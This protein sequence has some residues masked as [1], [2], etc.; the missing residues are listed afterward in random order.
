MLLQCG[1]FQRAVNY[2]MMKIPHRSPQI[3]HLSNQ[4]T[5]PEGL[6]NLPWL[7]NNVFIFFDP[8][9]ESYG[10][11]PF[12]WELCTHTLCGHNSCEFH[13][14]YKNNFSMYLPMNPST[15]QNSNDIWI[16]G[17]CLGW[18]YHDVSASQSSHLRSLSSHLIFTFLI[19]TSSN[20][21]SSV[22]LSSLL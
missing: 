13:I 18:G 9:H 20:Y 17:G 2:H 14:P 12:V 11:I 10:H 4:T 1:F 5:P 16:W 8:L 7:D 3:Y 19:F 22:L 6:L 21:Q 15:T